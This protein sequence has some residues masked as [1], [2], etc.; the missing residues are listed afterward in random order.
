[1]IEDYLGFVLAWLPLFYVLAR[2]YWDLHIVDYVES[3]G[4]RPYDFVVL[5]FLFSAATTMIAIT[6]LRS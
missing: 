1:M 5:M 3:K 4:P 6:I 2:R